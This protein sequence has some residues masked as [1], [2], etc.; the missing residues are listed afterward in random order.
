M[1]NRISP[2]ILIL[3]LFVFGCNSEKIV[4]K[5]EELNPDA[6]KPQGAMQA[7]M[8]NACVGKIDEATQYFSENL[9]KHPELL[10]EGLKVFETLCKE[11]GGFKNDRRDGDYVCYFKNGQIKEKAA[12]KN[13]KLVGR[14]LSFTEDGASLAE[15]VSDEEG[16]RRAWDEKEVAGL[17]H[18]LAH[19]D[20]K[21]K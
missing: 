17:L 18:D 6:D 14:F 21:Q 20:K 19:F 16:S 1:K 3:I 7:Y 10:R 15:E 9:R 4:E 11:K 8:R 13:G 12:Y 2:L 5:L